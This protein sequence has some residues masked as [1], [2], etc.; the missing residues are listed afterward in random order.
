MK[1]KNAAFIAIAS[2]CVELLSARDRGIYPDERNY[3]AGANCR[4]GGREP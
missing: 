1:S 4:F 3:F 2:L